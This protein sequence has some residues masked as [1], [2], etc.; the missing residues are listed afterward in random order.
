MTSE[1]HEPVPAVEPPAPPP[2]DVEPPPPP[3]YEP[4]LSLIT[5]LEKGLDPE[6]VEHR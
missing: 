1:Q 2:V 5:D 6:D 4:D 3:P